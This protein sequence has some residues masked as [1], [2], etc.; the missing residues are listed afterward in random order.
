MQIAILE[1]PM[2]EEARREVDAG[3]TE[4]ISDLLNDNDEE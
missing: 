2:A 1:H 4:P 3:K